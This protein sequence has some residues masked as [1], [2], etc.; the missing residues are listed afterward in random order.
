MT[1]LKYGS[2]GVTAREI[3]LS[4]PVAQ[5]PVGVPAGVIGTSLKG[6]AFV[7][8]T[9]GTL[10]DFYAKFGLT[11]GKKFGPL[12]VTEWLRNAGAVTYLRV[13]GVGD[14]KK[15]LDSG[16]NEG[17]V[18]NA[19]FT[20]GER[21]PVASLDGA[22]GHNP[23]ANVG[24][25][26]GRLYFLG[27]LMSESAGSTVFSEAGLQTSAAAAPIIRGV[28]MAP[29]GVI[30]RVS[31]S[32]EGTNS[33]PSS[34]AVASDGT[35]NGMHIGAV[36]LMDV[37][38]AKSEFVLLLNGH[39]GTDPLYKNYITASFDMTSDSYFAKVLNTDPTKVQKAGHCLYASWDVHPTQA[40]VTGTSIITAS[41]GA[42]GSDVARVGAE[43]AAFITTGSL[44]RDTADSFVPNYE[45]FVDRFSSAKSPWIISQ[46]FGG[47]PT[48]LFR[49]HAI[50]AGAG[51]S[52]NYKISIENIIKSNDPTNRYGTFDVVIRD[53]NDNDGAQ[54]PIE[55]FTGVTLN[56][57]SDNYIAKA[58]GDA[59]IFYD[60]DRVE[61]AQK[62]VVDGNYPNNSNY[63]R[64]E[65]SQDV[66]SGLVDETALPLG[67]RG[68][69]HLVTSGTMPLASPAA[70]DHAVT[71]VLKKATTPPVPFRKNIK[72]GS[73]PKSSANTNLY[74]GAQFE[75]VLSLA[76][77]NESLVKNDSLKSFA[78]FFPSFSSIYQNVVAGD[79]AGVVDTLEN[80][81][82]DSDRFCN[83][84]FTL[85]NLQVVTGSAD[86][87]NMA[88]ARSASYVR[89]GSIV[90]SDANKTR[91]VKESDFTST[92][93][94]LLKFT[95]FMQGGF[96]GVNI[97]D[98]DETAIN[99]NAVTADMN[100]DTRSRDKGPNV[101]SY[102]KAL[103][104]MKN[105]VN[106]EMQ[107]LA[108]PGIRHPIVTNAAIDAVQER[109]DA[110]YIMD[111]EQ[112]DTEGNDVT[113]PTQKV[114]VTAT[115]QKFSDRTLDSSF[116]AAYFPD[117]LM[118]DPNTK[119]NVVAPPSVAVL[120]A[121][122]LNDAV[123]YP[124]FA[125]AGFTR[126][127]L[128]TVQEA[129]VQL[130]K[131]NLDALYDVKINPI[132]AFPGSATSG[133]NP[134]G[135]VVVWGQKTLQAAASAL[136]RVNVRRLLIEIR[137]QV[138][139]I[140]QTI[141]FEPN[142]ESTLAKFSAAVTP[143]L[144]RI[145]S[146]AGLERFRVIIDSS[147]TT[148]ADVMNNTIRG[149]IYVQP[150]KSVEFVSIDFVVSNPGTI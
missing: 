88:S 98:A 78:K 112:V 122:S 150:T 59:H 19:G 120:G 55:K 94:S 21:Q 77:P 54:R 86:T 2:A 141:I 23:Y 114:S 82:M 107:L 106:T 146:L 20:V 35:A 115:A 57:S 135:G 3:D 61:S 73:G 17:S 14:G 84:V 13:L 148:E 37:T 74:W 49:F 67:Y 133:T 4:G 110:L 34:A 83:N 52:S 51:V 42:G 142:R 143:R 53:W 28:L 128:S 40:V 118:Q 102:A 25:E 105:T 27:A 81:V 126:G 18:T 62:L 71:E 119:S 56:P 5:Q 44:A 30:L 111:I 91:A 47:F 103:E 132:V 100:S 85:E 93:K 7:P 113:L 70:A 8:V 109:F 87:I 124:W 12:A 145:Q 33:A 6:P 46:K 26:P 144:T 139:E 129:T 127:A 108:I 125:P 137:R 58:I 39:K 90:A 16:V 32:S 117:L 80:G 72:I 36:V 89:G 11:D 131:T 97:F 140:A 136:D 22:L 149:K 123:G 138:R 68:V 92:N 15:R 60:F 96:D 1:Q 75:H 38:V 69:E 63:V 29:S 48:N 130:K 50:D 24:A 121:L 66:E 9:V 116:A 134:K 43:A 41:A 104:I 79:N 99:N 31:S 65:V 76:A 64:V 95:L 45:S 101:K 10:S 147:T